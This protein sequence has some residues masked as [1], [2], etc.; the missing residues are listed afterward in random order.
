MI[1]EETGAMTGAA[2][3]QD[4]AAEEAVAF[5]MILT[6]HSQAQERCTRQYAQ[7]AEQNAKCRLSQKKEDQYTAGNAFQSINLKGF[8]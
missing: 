6:G 7:I 5:E 3:S 4:L 1:E 8:S 2:S